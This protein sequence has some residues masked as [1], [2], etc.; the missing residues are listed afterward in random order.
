MRDGPSLFAFATTSDESSFYL[1]RMAREPFLETRRSFVAQLFDQLDDAVERP[2]PGLVGRAV[3]ELVDDLPTRALVA[4]AQEARL[5]RIR[6]QGARSLAVALGNQLRG[7]M[8]PD[9]ARQ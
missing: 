9:E 7:A 6:E 5:G 8:A 3:A 2:R 4:D 1:L